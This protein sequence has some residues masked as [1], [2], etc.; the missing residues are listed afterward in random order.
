MTRLFAVLCALLGIVWSGCGSN[1]PASLEFVDITPTTPRIGEITTIRFK[2]IDSRGEPQAG[3]QIHFTI[4][5]DVPNVT[6]SPATAGTNKG[7]GVAETQLVAKGRVSSVVVIAE[8]EGKT[9]VSP[10]ITFAGAQANAKQFTFECGEFGG[11]SS[12]GLRA[13]LAF[14]ESRS[15]VPGIQ[16]NCIAHV[17]D[18]NGEGVS[19]AQVSFLVEA[20][21]IGPTETSSSDV[22]GNAKILYKSSLPLPHATDPDN[23]TWSPPSD[24]NHTGDYIAPLW[25]MPYEWVQN[26]IVP[27]PAEKFQEPRRPDPIVPGRTN[28]PRDNLVAMI[29]VTTGEE[30]FDDLNNNGVWDATPIPEPYTDTTEP[31]VDSNDNGTW[32]SDE[33]YVD[34]NNNGKWDGK[35]G[36]YDAS[37]LIWASNHILW[38]GI[39][40]PF[41]DVAPSATN[42]KPVFRV[43]SPTGAV[44]ITHFGCQAYAVIVADPWFNSI[45]RNSDDDGCGVEGTETVIANPTSFGNGIR[46]T[47]PA[48]TTLT[49][50]LCD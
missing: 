16:A 45:A 11:A 48:A 24:A 43:I 7:S 31:F 37:T 28:N 34:T 22:V 32:D 26:P 47:Y 41:E 2:A 29:A 17:A 35:N 30:A 23:F 46:L 18:R 10:P 15:L 12:G 21:A 33:R 42:P 5:G 1:P 49:Y 6:L 9:A 4:Q 39:P 20:G 13:L 38:T 25:M 14:D 36:Q 8:S 40:N 19:G 44:A 50:S 3:A 27:N